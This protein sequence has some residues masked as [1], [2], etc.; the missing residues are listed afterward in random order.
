MSAN[1]PNVVVG[2]RGDSLRPQALTIPDNPEIE[3]GS[4]LQRDLD[5]T[6]EELGCSGRHRLD[7]R[8]PVQ[9][10]TSPRTLHG[11]RRPHRAELVE[12][13]SRTV[14]SQRPHWP[15]GE[16]NRGPTTATRSDNQTSPT[17][18]RRISTLGAAGGLH[19]RSPCRYRTARNRGVVTSYG[20]PATTCER[21]TLQLRTRRSRRLACIE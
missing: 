10:E 2:E 21:A 3:V 20:S 15:R 1:S 5:V 14:V 17:L 13:R 16:D 11:R 7:H 9:A 6:L 8:E 18:A 12:L 19:P 4:R